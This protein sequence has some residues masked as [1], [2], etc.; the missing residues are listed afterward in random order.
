MGGLTSGRL[1]TIPVPRG[2]KSLPT[3]FYGDELGKAKAQKVAHLQDGGLPTT[4]RTDN[5][6][7]GQVLHRAQLCSYMGS[8]AK[9][10]DVV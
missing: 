2:K 5:C 3:M 9:T 8:S 7:L 4:L 10:Y 6:D 1:V